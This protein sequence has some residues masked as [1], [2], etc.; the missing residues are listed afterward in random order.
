MENKDFRSRL[1]N[2]QTELNAD[3]WSQMSE[4]LDTLPEEKQRGSKRKIW[5]LLSLLGIVLTAS[6]VYLSNSN[7]SLVS[8][9]IESPNKN[10]PSKTIE[11]N[12]IDSENE[13]AFT[14]RKIEVSPEKSVSI[15]ENSVSNRNNN[16]QSAYLKSSSN[17]FQNKT[18]TKNK[19]KQ[20]PPINKNRELQINSQGVKARADKLP[21]DNSNANSIN[22]TANQISREIKSKSNSENSEETNNS[23]VSPNSTT[24]LNTGNNRINELPLIE[25]LKTNSLNKNAKVIDLAPKIITIKNINRRK[26]FWTAAIGGSDIN[27]NR[28]YYLGFGAFW[29]ANKVIGFETD[30]SFSSA[31]DINGNSNSFLNSEQELNLTVWVH[32]NLVRTENHKFSLEVGPSIG[33]NW[34]IIKNEIERQ[35]NLPYYNLKAGA[36]YT[37]FMSNKNGIGIKGAFSFYDSG[38]VAFR[39]LKK[40]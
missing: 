25:T 36:S 24:S 10:Q 31:W 2:H 34:F 15:N 19:D 11:K 30:L 3:A 22:S 17:N 23:S 28:G 9:N 4:M 6:F 29:D 20:S 18:R 7:S 32:L 14:S 12:N 5:I 16:V 33:S 35:R 1:K 21:D 13:S 8:E 27:G 40:F 39:Y 37:Y 26:L 38:Y